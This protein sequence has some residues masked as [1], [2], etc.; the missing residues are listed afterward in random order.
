MRMMEK[1]V[2]KKYQCMGME[3]TEQTLR[4]IAEMAVL[5]SPDC[6]SLADLCYNMQEA[7]AQRVQ[8][9]FREQF[10]IGDEWEPVPEMGTEDFNQRVRV[11]TD[12][13][14]DMKDSDPEK[15]NELVMG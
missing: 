14:A 12:W 8:D 13:L 5:I 7:R 4:E 6:A 11:I 1:K 15:F 9:E 2:E 10:S 3:R